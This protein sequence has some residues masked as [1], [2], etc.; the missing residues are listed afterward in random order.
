L[1][2]QT[3]IP[4]MDQVQQTFSP[5]VLIV[6][7]G[8]PTEFRNNDDVLHNV[9]VREDETRSGAFNVA[10]P[11]GE[12]YVFTFPRD[13]FYDVGCDIHPG[14]SAQIV[15]VSSP[16]AT[17]ADEQGNFVIQNVESGTYNAVL[18]AGGQKIVKAITIAPGQSAL[19]L[20]AP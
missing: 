18:Y 1:P 5:P 8:E 15:S 6:R 9:R 13:G 3:A 10:I 4:Y 17:L 20:R 16:Y 19:D 12:K 11:T 2:P 7:T 14:M